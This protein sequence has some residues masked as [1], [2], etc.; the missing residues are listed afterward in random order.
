MRVSEYAAGTATLVA[1][2]VNV[3]VPYI[4][5]NAIVTLTRKTAG[6]TIGDL[7]WSIGTISGST[8]TITITSA[9][10]TDTSTVAYRISEPYA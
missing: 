4:T 10:G 7:T 6:G 9:S 5:A 2:T 1:G 3:T 8:T